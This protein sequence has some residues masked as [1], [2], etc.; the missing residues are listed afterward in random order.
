MDYSED[1]REEVREKFSEVARVPDD[2]IDMARTSLLISRIEYPYLEEYR[3]LDRLEDM[4]ARVRLRIAGISR[5]QQRVAEM[6]QLLFEE[7]GFR[8]NSENYY[9]PGNSFLNRV[10][11]SKLGIPITLSLVY[12]EVGRRAN[13]NLQGIDLP[14]HFIAGLFEETERIFLDP[15]DGGRILSEEEC[16]RRVLVYHGGSGFFNAHFL[17]PVG[18]KTVL[19]RMLRNLKGIYRHIREEL[20]VFQMIEWILALRPDA[21]RELRERG[22]IYEAMG[23]FDL[24]VRD[25]K[26]Y[27]EVSLAS[28]D[29]ETIVAKVEELDGKTSQLH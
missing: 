12:M 26:R 8:G 18:P 6:N 4:A 28:E 10:L 16:R 19:V 5:P 15:F 17:D 27:L 20:K 11:D 14:G 24:A 29:R 25:L 13:L 2:K 3:Y 22:F 21:A 23:A 9:D 1:T 7:E